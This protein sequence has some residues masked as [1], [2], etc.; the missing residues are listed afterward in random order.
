MQV[1][2]CGLCRQQD[3]VY[4]NAAQPDYAGFVFWNQSRRY[5]TREKAAQ[6]KEKL[7]SRIQAVGVFVDEPP[8]A[9]LQL[10]SDGIMDIAQLHGAE[11][12]EEIVWL[13]KKSGRPV[14]KAVVVKSAADVE[15]WRL[16][17][18]DMLLFDGGRGE[19]RPFLW[20][21]LS[22][23]DRPFFLA[24]GMSPERLKGIQRHPFLAGID[25]SSG[26]ETDGKKDREKMCRFVQQVRGLV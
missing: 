7:D 2:I 16:S 5:V 3:A 22:G 11:T 1:K 26:V 9:I 8:D 10:F 24:G 25:V 20:E 4:A 12:E 18:A 14:W 19:G 6:L 21:Y 13:K 17:Q 15:R 23:C